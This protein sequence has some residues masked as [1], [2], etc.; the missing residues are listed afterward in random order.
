M[1]KSQTFV[2]RLEAFI[3]RRQQPK[4]ELRNVR[5]HADGRERHNTR[6]GRNFVLY[7][8]SEYPDFPCA[9]FIDPRHSELRGR[10][11]HTP[12]CLG[13]EPSFYGCAYGPNVGYVGC[14][15]FHGM[16]S[17]TQ[18]DGP[19][20]PKSMSLRISVRCKLPRAFAPRRGSPRHFV[21]ELRYSR[22]RG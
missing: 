14:N 7:Y 13:A 1:R 16:L 12:Y 5:R 9:P 18:A 11:R 19:E 17:P 21:V 22:V 4:K 3:L 20:Q 6:S 10:L 2:R 8:Y 15:G